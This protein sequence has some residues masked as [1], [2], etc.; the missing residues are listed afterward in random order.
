MDT[1]PDKPRVLVF[2]LRNIFGNAL[3]R[4]SDYEFEDIIC[5]IDSAAILAPKLDPYSARSKFAMRLSYHF[6]VMLNPGIKLTEKN[7]YDLFFAVCGGLASPY[8]LIMLNAAT[9]ARD[10]CRKSVC[11]LDEVW[12]KQ[13]HK[14]RYFLRVLEKFDVVMLYF[15]QTVQQLSELIGK[16]CI[17][18][19]PGIDTTLFCPY[20]NPPKRVVDVYSIGRRS[21]TTHQKL[22]DMVRESGLLYL[23][24]SVEGDQA[25]DTKEHRALFAN[26]AKRSRYFIV[27]PGLIDKPEKRGNQFEFG[28]RY[29]EGAASGAIM[30]GE[31]PANEEFERLFDWPE[32]VTQIP[33]NSTNIDLVIRRLD[34]DPERQD[35]IRRNNVAQA[36]MRHDWVYR[37]ENVLEAAGLEPLEGVFER[38]KRLG[39]LA[40]VV[41]QNE[42]VSGPA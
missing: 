37:W 30:I 36:L 18:L 25:I 10:L 22:L 32:A 4:C 14:H 19:P 24:D 11:L 21:K 31:R 35:A 29:L 34:R 41:L 42:Q 13:L 38:K 27:N 5:E 16:R 23:Y 26:I 33:F 2:S 39:K 40:E 3:F 9:N 8:D 15:S 6:P 12:I 17:F 7:H 20:P 28:P 1:K